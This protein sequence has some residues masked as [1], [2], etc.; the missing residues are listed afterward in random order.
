MNGN[1]YTA[2][3]GFWVNFPARFI[4][5]IFHFKLRKMDDWRYSIHS[6]WIWPIEL[7]VLIFD[8]MGFPDFIM[9]IRLL[10]NKDMR[11]LTSEEINIIHDFYGV[12]PF[13]H[14]IWMNP[15][16]VFKFRRFAYAFVFHNS[17]NYHLV[18]TVP[19]LIHEFMHV[20]QY[21]LV[22][23]VYIVRALF[24][25]RSIEGYNY[26][27]PMTIYNN[28]MVGKKIWDY[29]YEQQAQIMQDYYEISRSGSSIPIVIE[30]GYESL[31]LN[32]KEEVM[33]L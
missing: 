18:I 33:K 9:Q 3:L 10:V 31:L 32:V 28:M 13:T 15:R 14:K 24:A 25:Q 23:S 5:L 8:L 12:V 17:I 2:F 16:D 4:R 30:A 20:I 27:S 11:K 1:R 21:H 19:V 26:G 29:N 22:G 6:I 7:I